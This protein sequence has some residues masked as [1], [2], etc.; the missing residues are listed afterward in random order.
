MAHPEEV[1]LQALLLSLPALAPGFLL[2]TAR[3]RTAT[4][5]I[6]FSFAFLDRGTG[7]S[8]VGATLLELLVSMGRLSGNP[9]LRG[10]AFAYVELLRNT[11]LLLQLF[12]WYFGTLLKLPPWEEAVRLGGSS[13]P[14]GG[15]CR[16]GLPWPQGHGRL[17]LSLFGSPGNALVALFPLAGLYLL[18]K[19]LVLWAMGAG[20]R[21]GQGEPTLLFMGQLPQGMA[22]RA[23]ALLGAFLVAVASWLFGSSPSP[24]LRPSCS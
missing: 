13:S 24:S 22:W 8:L 6:P 23:R 12:T 15:W 2:A 16:L 5:G 14:K 10:I 20:W 11:P 19:P 17:W 21:V 7:F 3:D 9:L 18:G 1:L 4:Q